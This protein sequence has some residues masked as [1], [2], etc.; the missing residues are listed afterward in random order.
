MMEA[1]EQEV[2]AQVL[3]EARGD[4]EGREKKVKV[5]GSVLLYCLEVVVVLIYS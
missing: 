1:I 5:R 3:P 2:E 4:S